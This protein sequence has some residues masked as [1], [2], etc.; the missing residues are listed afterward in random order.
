[1]NLPSPSRILDAA[2]NAKLYGTFREGFTIVLGVAIIAGSRLL[3]G[4][5][6]WIVVAMGTIT[7]ALGFCYLWLRL[8]RSRGETREN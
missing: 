5:Q 4:P 7:F 3:S 6:E 2:A 1:M 8:H